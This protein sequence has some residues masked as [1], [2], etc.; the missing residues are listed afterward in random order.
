MIVDGDETDDDSIA[1]EPVTQALPR[2]LALRR[3]Q[4][5]QKPKGPSKLCK[6]NPPKTKTSK[7]DRDA[8]LKE[9]EAWAL[10]DGGGVRGPLHNLVISSPPKPV[11]ETS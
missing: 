6:L 4:P 10:V 1:D 7:K 11:S 9:D 2:Q 8:E 5:E 3:I